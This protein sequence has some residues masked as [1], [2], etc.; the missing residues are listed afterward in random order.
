MSAFLQYTSMTAKLS[1]KIQYSFSFCGISFLLSWQPHIMG[2]FSSCRW[3]SWS[4]TCCISCSDMHSGMS[5]VLCIVSILI[6]M[7]VT[8]PPFFLL[9][10]S[11]FTTSQLWRGLVKACTVSLLGTGVFSE[12]CIKSLLTVWLCPSW[13]LPLG[14]CGPWI[15]LL[16]WQSN[17]GETSLYNVVFPVLLFS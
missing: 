4:V 12:V 10:S 7:S 9:C 6:F 2:S 8:L 13:R 11:V 15:Y 16:H 17:S 5:I 14:P 1:L 3:S